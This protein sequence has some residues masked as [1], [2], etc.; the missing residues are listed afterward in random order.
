LSALYRQSARLAK[1]AA[2]GHVVRMSRTIVIG[3][4]IVGSCVAYFLAEHGDVVV[5]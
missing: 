4:G 3:G 5:L 1:V 2:A